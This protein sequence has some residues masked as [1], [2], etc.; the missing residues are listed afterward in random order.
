MYWDGDSLMG[1]IEVLPTPSGKLLTELYR[2]GCQVGV[3]S[4]GWASLKESPSGCITVQGDF[5][6]IT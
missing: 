5:E 1:V 3:S 4:R 6:L 2:E